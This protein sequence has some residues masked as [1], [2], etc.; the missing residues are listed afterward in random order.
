MLQDLIWKHN[1]LIHLEPGMVLLAQFKQL[2]QELNHMDL[3]IL[4]GS[5][6][7]TMDLKITQLLTQPLKPPMDNN[8]TVTSPPS[9]PPPTKLRSLP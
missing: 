3:N 2:Q 4:L 9:A 7:D 6:Q 1:N 5:P 8:S